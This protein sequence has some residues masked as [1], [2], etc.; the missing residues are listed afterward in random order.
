[1]PRGVNMIM[2][3][4]KENAVTLP[5]Y[6]ILLPLG[7]RPIYANY[8]SHGYLSSLP[9]DAIV[10][11]TEAVDGQAAPDKPTFIEYPCGQGRVLAACQCFHDRDNSGRGPLMQTVLSYAA[12]KK[13]YAAA[14]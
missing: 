7:G 4:A 3:P 14:K 5:D 9:P 13:W 8:A 6:P 10:L 12:A 1:M 2:R 11:A